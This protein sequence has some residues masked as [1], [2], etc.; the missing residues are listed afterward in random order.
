MPTASQVRQYLTLTVLPVLAGA[1]A[2]WL[3]IHVHFL[4]AFHIT[5]KSVAGELIQLGVFGIAAGIGW[6]AS[7]H[8]LKGT[9]EPPSTGVP[10]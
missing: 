3:V 8:I 5:A 6:L 7:H 2:D 4:A 1:A 10:K 9:Y